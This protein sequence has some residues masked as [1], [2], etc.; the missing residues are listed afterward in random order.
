MPEYLSPDDF[1]WVEKFGSSDVQ[2]ISDI[3]NVGYILEVDQNYS[4]HLRDA[5]LDLPLR[6]IH[7][8][9]PPIENKHPKLLTTLL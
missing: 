6:P 5:H 3:S 9:L 7:E 8:K 1:K 4:E 2:N